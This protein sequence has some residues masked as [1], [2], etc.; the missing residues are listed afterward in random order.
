MTSDLLPINEVQT[1][2]L[3]DFDGTD[4]FRVRFGGADSA[5]ITRGANYAL[6]GIQQALQ[7]VSEVQTVTRGTGPFTLG[8]QGAETAPIISGSDPV[9]PGPDRRRH[10]RRAR[11]RRAGRPTT[12]NVAAAVNAIPGFPGTVT[13]NGAGNT[14]FTLTFTQASAG[15]AL[16]PVEIVNCTCTATVRQTAN[17]GPPP[18][19]WPAGGTVTVGSLTDTGFTLTFSGAHQGTDVA[20]VSASDGTVVETVKGTQGMLSPGATAIVAAWGTSASRAMATAPSCAP[21]PTCGI[22]P[23]CCGRCEW[24]AT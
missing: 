13:S 3:R 8:Y 9:V 5:P 10:Q 22:T 4:S 17:G 1:I 18:A 7:G 15:V 6:P 21:P 12:A 23:G 11:G 14:G 2:S 24:R 20:S 16:P 19:T